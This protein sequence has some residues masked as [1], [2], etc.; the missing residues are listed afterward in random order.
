[1]NSTEQEAEELA[2]CIQQHSW[3]TVAVVTSNYHTRRARMIWKK[4]I[5]RRNA[6]VQLSVLGVADPEYQPRGWWRQRLYA[7][8]WF[9]E[10]TK[11]LW[12]L[13]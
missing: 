12:T 5:S 4:T 1:V 8:T 9:M 7:K 11:L 13:F 2:A 10:S 3:K 6:S